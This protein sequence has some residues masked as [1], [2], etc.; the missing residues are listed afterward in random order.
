MSLLQTHQ[1]KVNFER[2]SSRNLLIHT[3]IQG[4]KVLCPQQ[5][6]TSFSCLSPAGLPSLPLLLTLLNHFKADV[7][8]RDAN[9]LTPLC[10][11]CRLGHLRVAEVGV[12]L[13]LCGCSRQGYLLQVLVCVGGADMRIRDPDLGQTALHYAALHGHPDIVQ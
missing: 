1:F 3:A 9:G 5:G 11:A 2:D 10:L 13:V 4:G 12:C 7:N 6:N 8:S